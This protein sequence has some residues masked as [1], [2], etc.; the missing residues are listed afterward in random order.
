MKTPTCGM[1]TLIPKGG[2]DSRKTSR[3]PSL[4]GHSSAPFLSTPTTKLPCGTCPSSRTRLEA[5]IEVELSKAANTM[6]FS[7]SEATPRYLRVVSNQ[8]PRAASGAL[9]IEDASCSRGCAGQNQTK[10]DTTRAEASCV[11]SNDASGMVPPPIVTAADN[12]PVSAAASRNAASSPA[13]STAADRGPGT[14]NV[15]V[16]PLA[17]MCKE[18][19]SKHLPSRES[20]IAPRGITTELKVTSYNNLP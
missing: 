15:T 18:P 11:T 9:T 5:R 16:S 7:W 4:V 3:H 10:S 13:L 12:T 14:T 1:R 8:T 20:R 17:N 2:D 19:E 6:S